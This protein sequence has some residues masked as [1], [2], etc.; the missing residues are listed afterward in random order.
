MKKNIPFDEVKG[1]TSITMPLDTRFPCTYCDYKSKDKSNVIQHI[2]AVHEKRKDYMCS[3]CN[4]A[5]SRRK[6]LNLHIKEV[7][8]KIKDYEC[9]L[10][11]FKCAQL[12]NL[13]RHVKE[14]H[15]KI[16][17]YECLV[18]GCKFAR[19]GN[20]IHHSKVHEKNKQ[21]PDNTKGQ[22]EP[23]RSEKYDCTG[24][25]EKFNTEKKLMKHGLHCKSDT[26]RKKIVCLK[27]GFTSAKVSKWARHVKVP[28]GQDN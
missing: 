24:C 3:L 27:C 22:A 19:N 9:K 8:W 16:K 18:C 7:H 20:L 6:N 17:A 12:C 1:L 2:K 26:F 21:V 11:D 23:K 15:K 5:A 14:V 25:N 10:C 13:R 28:C 4:F